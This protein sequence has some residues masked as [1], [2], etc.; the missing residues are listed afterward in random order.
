[1]AAG[2]AT[3]GGTKLWASAVNVAGVAGHAAGRDE[4]VA[5]RG[6]DGRGLGPAGAAAAP[7]ATTRARRPRAAAGEMGTGG[8]T[9]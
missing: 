3:L 8:L 4:V 5:D 7:N 6:A 1:V 2:H 9:G